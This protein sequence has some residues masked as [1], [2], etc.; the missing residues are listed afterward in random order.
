MMTLCYVDDVADELIRALKNEENRQG[1]YCAVPIEHKITLGEIADLLYSFKES[2]NTKVIPDMTDGSFSKK[3]Y[4][5]Y[6]SYLAPD[7][8]A[9]K[10]KMNCDARGS[11]TEI[12][13][14]E[15][16]G[17]FSVNISKP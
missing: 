12:L 11:F 9:Y 6:L 3:L 7:N 15:N 16:A 2:R 13:R 4:S 8:F 14:S 5:T 17:Q 1:E 10:L